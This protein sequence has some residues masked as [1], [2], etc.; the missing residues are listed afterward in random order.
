MLADETAYR[1]L[2]YL[3][4]SGGLRKHDLAPL[5][6][7]ALAVG[8]DL[9][10]SAPSASRRSRSSW[11]SGFCA[12]ANPANSSWSARTASKRAFQ[13]CSSSAAT[14]RALALVLPRFYHFFVY[15]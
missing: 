5:G 10:T 3:E 12:A 15:F 13:R 8:S 2:A 9:S 14:R 11:V 7:R 6:A 1:V 4:L